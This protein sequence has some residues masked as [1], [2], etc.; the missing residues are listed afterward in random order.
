[1]RGALRDFEDF[2]EAVKR[3]A[4]RALRMAAGGEKAETAKPLRGFG[5]GVFEIV[6]RHRGDAFRVV[7]GLQLDADVW[8][9]HAFQKKSKRGIATPKAETDLIRERIRRL[10]EQL[11]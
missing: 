1:M 7:Y 3:A 4:V 10:L 5:S 8:V 11:R 2:P 6:L 9:L